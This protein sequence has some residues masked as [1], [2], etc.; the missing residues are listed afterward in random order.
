MDPDP[1]ATTTYRKTKGWIYDCVTSHPKCG[2]ARS[3]MLP[4]RVLD[5]LPPGPGNKLRLYISC[6]GEE[7]GYVA[8]SYCCKS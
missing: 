5:V 3:R 4:T 8:L 6:K 1:T 7:S 2:F